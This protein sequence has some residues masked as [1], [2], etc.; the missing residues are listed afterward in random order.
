MTRMHARIFVSISTLLMTC[1][2]ATGVII[3]HYLLAEP[4]SNLT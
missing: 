2:V 3:L 4:H 1:D